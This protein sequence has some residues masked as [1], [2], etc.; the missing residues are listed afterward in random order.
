M[1]PAK[2]ISLHCTCKS[3][4]YLCALMIDRSTTGAQL[5]RMIESKF[6][7]I[8]E[9]IFLVE[10]ESL[11][12]MDTDTLAALGVINN[13]NIE[14]IKKSKI[15][16]KLSLN[17]KVMPEN[18]TFVIDTLT[19]TST[20]RD[21]KE[22]IK[23]EC[24]VNGTFTLTGVIGFSSDSDT[25]EDCMN[26]DSFTVTLQ[27]TP[28]PRVQP[29]PVNNTPPR[30]TTA[31]PPRQTTA[32]PSPAPRTTPVRTQPVC[33][34]DIQICVDGKCIK[35]RAAIFETDT[36]FDI[37][38]IIK[39]EMRLNVPLIYLNEDQTHEILDGDLL[40]KHLADG[41]IIYGFFNSHEIIEK[42]EKRKIVKPA[43]T[44]GRTSSSSAIRKAPSPAEGTI[45]KEPKK[46]KPL[47]TE[48]A[49]VAPLQPPP[50]LTDQKINAVS[51]PNIGGSSTPPSTPP[52]DHW[53]LK[54][55][56]IIL[57]KTIGKGGFG[58]VHLA[59]W[60]NNKVAVKQLQEIGSLNEE[61]FADFMHESQMIANLNHPQIVRLYGI[62]LDPPYYMVMEFMAKGSLFDVIRKEQLSWEKKTEIAIDIA[63]GLSFLHDKSIVHRDIKSLNVLIGPHYEVKLA[64]FGLSVVKQ[65]QRS[66]KGPTDGNTG[67]T[68]WKAPELFTDG[69]DHTKAS[70][71]FSLGILYWELATHKAPFEHKKDDYMVIV[72]V[73]DGDRDKIPA[74]VP[75]FYKEVIESC[76]SQEA[77]DRPTINQVVELLKRGK[78]TKSTATI[79]R[80]AKNNN[81]NN[82]NNGGPIQIQNQNQNQNQNQY[83][84]GV[85]FGQQDY[86][87]FQQTPMASNQFTSAGV[88]G[89]FTHPPS[90]MPPT[91]NNFNQ[92][93]FSSGVVFGQ[94]P[95]NNNQPPQPIANININNNNINLS[96]GAYVQ[97]PQQ[98]NKPFQQAPM[99]SNQFTSAGAGGAY[100]QP[101]Q[102]DN[103]NNQNQYSS[104]VVYGQQPLNNNPPSP[105]ANNNINLS[106]GAYVQTP[107]QS[108]PPSSIN[109][110][111]SGAQ[112]LPNQPQQSFN[113]NN[114]N[115]YSSSG[116]YV[117]QSY[118]PPANNYNQY[119]SGA[120]VPQAG[121]QPP[122]GGNFNQ[123]A[124]SNQFNNF[125]SG[126][127]L[128]TK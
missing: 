109:Q 23:V 117:P 8:V 49:K 13:D 16:S 91:D 4:G 17:I 118:T 71:I 12:M 47:K 27:S 79:V 86:K 67:T 51:L 105:V 70:D 100:A 45:Q 82:N 30:Q 107:Q 44:G 65:S 1:A 73:R 5:R 42:K 74:D 35:P 69:G 60:F 106:S 104:G 87:P 29:K 83:S 48:S 72:A 6:N 56:D 10:Q 28:A 14:I 102:I 103:Y 59:K 128:P 90:S 62:T 55:N 125:N 89:A 21:L 121:N 34:N 31:T 3:Q 111:S 110:Y 22:R 114:N 113:N 52:L 99:A 77:R 46:K 127:F 24:K 108:Q 115:Q 19:K 112:F 96:S 120:Y 38:Q 33:Y 75:P 11:E 66:A 20:I 18:K 101:P 25:L 32:T 122:S 9:K 41:D 80:P 68:R 54:H 119:S 98:D 36:G 78:K 123:A 40:S 124:P 88:G 63:L 53:K 2:T 126:G 76:W 39:D 58:T 15:S 26:G 43:P 93:Q 97:S 57:K 84:S 85:V 61:A 92:N 37:K 64:D 94:P 7:C 95:P 50:S 81:N 116:G